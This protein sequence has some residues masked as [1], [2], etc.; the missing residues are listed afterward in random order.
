MQQRK[1]VP[2]DVKEDGPLLAP[3]TST[4]TAPADNPT[5]KAKAFLGKQLFFDPRLS[6]DNTI[7]CASCHIPGKAYGDG[8]ALARGQ[9]DQLLTRNTQSC[10]NVGFYPSLFWDG[11]AATGNPWVWR[12]RFPGYHA[13]M[14]RELLARGYH[15]GY[16]DVAELFG[17]PT[18]VEIGNQF[19][20]FMTNERNLATRT[21]P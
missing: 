18:A 17:S 9:Q 12:A 7:S 13:E 2:E 15:I 4:P 19:Y 3:L 21:R 1:T 8:I 16:V 14:D 11:R 6:G 20:D 5:T 10:L